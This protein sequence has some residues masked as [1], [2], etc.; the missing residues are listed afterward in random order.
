MANV[1]VAFPGASARE[2]EALVSIPA[3]QVLAQMT[4][5][6]HVY[7]V[8]R[9]GMAFPRRSGVRERSVSAEASELD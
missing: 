7:S 3:E 5:I 9:P 2:V 4:G 8:S 6:E 1:F